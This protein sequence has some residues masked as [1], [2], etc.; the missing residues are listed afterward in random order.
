VRTL[1]P[2]NSSPVVQ[3]YAQAELCEEKKKDLIQVNPSFDLKTSTLPTKHCVGS[4]IAVRGF[5]FIAFVFSLL[6]FPRAAQGAPN[7]ESQNE[8][9]AID[10]ATAVQLV[11]VLTWHNDLARTGQNLRETQLTPANVNFATFGKLFQINVDGKVDAQPLIVSNV[12]L[13]NGTVHNV[14][15]IA[16]ENDTVYCCD[17]DHGTLLWRRSMLRAGETPSDSRNCNQVIPE[18]GITATPVIDLTTGPHGTIYVVAMSKN[19]TSYFQRL[20]ALDLTT[21]AEQFG[22]AMNIVATYPGTGDNNNGQGEVVFDPKQYDERA[23]L[24]ITGGI[25][26]TT[27]ASHCDQLPYTGWVIGYDKYT[28]ARIRVL[29]LTPNGEGGAI[30]ASGGAPAVDASGNIYALVA[31]GTFDTSLNA[32]GFP[33]KSDFG[34]CIVKMANP[35]Q[36]LRVV[37]YW[38]MG[39]TVAESAADLDLGSGNAT[40]LP[41]MVDINGITR[42]LLVGAGK[43]EHIYIA[44]RDNLGKFVPNSN[45]TL[46]QNVIGAL[47]GPVY[48]GAAYFNGRLYYGAVNDHLKSFVFVNARLR[49]TPTSQ[50]AV[51]FSYPGTTPSISANGTSNAIIWAAHNGTPAVLYAFDATNLAK[52]LYA[53]TDA[54]SRDYFGVGNKFIVPTVAN[55]KVYVGTTSSVGVF[56]LL[57]PPIGAVPWGD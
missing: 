15:I 13:P 24:V 6:A 2:A 47:A 25:V 56:G 4:T 52:K 16:T 27:W 44:N 3:S 55:G 30:W 5:L 39:N 41:P 22:E 46:Y 45:A 33:S 12:T 43:D 26:Y 18:I 36:Q 51:T 7:D 50:T 1:V 54:G 28:L 34:N 8:N 57:D 19:S 11:N 20:H 31:N 10:A 40:V 48:S 14:V 37:D 35:N 38:T 53:S 17:A 29:N 23:G 49:A 32:I 9:T 21:G 42:R